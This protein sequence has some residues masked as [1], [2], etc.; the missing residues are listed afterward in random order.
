[1]PASQLFYYSSKLDTTLQPLPTAWTDD[2][3]GPKSL[4]LDVSPGAIS[5]LEGSKN[6]CLRH[7]EVLA[8]TGESTVVAKP[9]GRGPGSVYQGPAEVD[10]FEAVNF[11]RRQFSI[12]EDRISVMGGSMGGAATWYLASHY[13]DFFAAA[14]PFCGYCDYRHW[15]KP[16][17]TVMRT[18]EWEHASWQS[19][20]AVFRAGNLSN[21]SLWIVHGEWDDSI[22]GGVPVQHSRNMSRLLT[23]LGIEHRY[24][25]VPECGHGC[26]RPEI[27]E[28]VLPWLSQQERARPTAVD[29]TAH[30]LRHNRS[31]FVQID[32][33]A[34]YG[35]PA[36]L[37]AA[38]DENALRVSAVENVRQFSLG[39]LDVQNVGISIAGADLGEFDLSTP[40]SFELKEGGWMRGTNAEDEDRSPH[41]WH[42][43]SGPIGDIFFK[44]VLVV[45]GTQG[46]AHENF[47]L[48]WLCPFW[49]S[50][51]KQ[52]NGGV[53]RGVFP[54]ESHYEIRVVK[55]TEVTDEELERHNLILAGSANSNSVVERIRNEL[56]LSV[57][58]ETLNLCDQEIAGDIGAVAVSPSPFNKGRV[59]VNVAGTSP[60]ALTGSSHLN[61]QL[62]PDYLVW[63]KE[64]VQ[65]G[66]FDENWQLYES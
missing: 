58:Q 64:Q 6:S 2:G 34:I 1:M 3:T 13:P 18:Q 31:H 4:I 17:G 28:E 12:D 53:H 16:G 30:T 20:S 62:L 36:C 14:A 51:F 50:S 5:N 42:G 43:C 49:V 57:G 45:Q 55:D 63:E 40:K 22:G 46:S 35:Q 21:T 54:G 52:H 9:C 8:E 25:E 48:D 38:L 47:V 11:L 29:L 23:N 24:T 26:M 41:K 66:F 19:R 10:F 56:P 39:P 44:P 15:P 37:R 32:A 7:A 33:F 60:E 59:V 65:H 27:L 61:F